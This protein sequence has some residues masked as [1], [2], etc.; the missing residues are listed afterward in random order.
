MNNNVSVSAIDEK[1][2]LTVEK[3]FFVMLF[4][5]IIRIGGEARVIC[6]LIRRST[7]FVLRLVSD[8]R[9]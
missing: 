3:F 8:T 7:V 6:K 5:L 1:D 4:R 2:S 9:K